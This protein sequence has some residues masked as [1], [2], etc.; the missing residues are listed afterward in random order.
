MH[1]MVTLK[2]QCACMPTLLQWKL[3]SLKPPV[4]LTDGGQQSLTW[5]M[6]TL[7]MFELWQN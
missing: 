6:A 2:Q 5:P 1:N 3:L 7:P 4:T